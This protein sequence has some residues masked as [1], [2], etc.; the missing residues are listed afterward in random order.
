M[1]YDFQIAPESLRIPKSAYR[2]VKR[3]QFC[4]SVYINGKF[5]ESCGSFL[6]YHP[7]GEPF[8][9]KSLYGIKERYIQSFNVINQFFPILE[10]KKSLAA[11]S[12]VRNL[13]KRFSDLISAFNSEDLITPDQ[14]KLFYVESVELID[15]LMRYGT[16]SSILEALLLENDG[17]LIGQELLLHLQNTRG[18]IKEEKAWDQQFL[19]H[20]LWGVLR[21]ESFLKFGIITATILTMAVVY[22]D[23]IS[24]QFGK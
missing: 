18:S 9:A 17:S 6:E 16:S 14:K 19:D 21:L 4:Q 10:N 5:C 1:D 20:Q 2:P 13:E 8:G 22:K 11:K 12:Y 24:S 7:I 3:C 15:E 23:I